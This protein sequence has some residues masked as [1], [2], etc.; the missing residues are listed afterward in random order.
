MHSSY[1]LY[2]Y[3]NL[4]PIG[5]DHGIFYIIRKKIDRPQHKELIGH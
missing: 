4:V 3:L 5:Y 1:D 2:I